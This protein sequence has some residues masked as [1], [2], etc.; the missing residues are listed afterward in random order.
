M[1]TKQDYYEILGVSK[2][3]DA[4]EIKRAYRE[5]AKKYHPDINPDKDA[6]K[7]FKEC[8]E[9]YEV[10]KDPQKKAAYDRYGHDAFTNGAGQGGFGGFSSGGFGDMSD[11]ADIFSDFF[12]GGFSSGKSGQRNSARRGEDILEHIEI[13]LKDAYSG[14]EQKVTVSKKTACPE[15]HGTGCKGDYHPETCPHC[16]GRGKIRVQQGFFMFEQTCPHCGGD[17]QVIK[18]PCPKC[19]GQGW[20]ITEKVLDLKVPAGIENGMKMRVSGEGN[21]GTRGGPN[22]DLYVL[23]SIK[24]HELFK[25]E[26]ADLYCTIPI[27]MITATLG[28]KIN[29]TLIDDTVEEIKIPAGTQT[30]T[31]F[32][33][34]NK[35][36]PKLKSGGARGNL[37]VKVKMTTPTKLNQKQ[38]DLLKEFA[39]ISGD[40]IQSPPGFIDKVKEF[41][42]L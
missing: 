26:E 33:L 7:K 8:S 23:V 42:D 11:L 10:L 1:S 40:E 41:L 4:G 12:G 32:T 20:E 38:K 6:E 37:Y 14:I 22:G 2:N 30:D 36:M 31:T 3:A 29:L 5:M 34:R 9:A 15:C 17:G 21:I 13:S 25:R 16:K 24:E 39:K 27:S 35:G 19:N 18:N 28:G